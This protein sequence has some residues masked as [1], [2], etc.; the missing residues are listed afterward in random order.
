[1]GPQG[2]G[3]RGRR[4]RKRGR[5]VPEGR[6]GRARGCEKR[7]AAEKGT[8]PKQRQETPRQPPSSPPRQLPELPGGFA[9]CRPAALPI[10]RQSAPAAGSGPRHPGAFHCSKPPFLAAHDGNCPKIALEGKCPLPQAGCLLIGAA[11]VSARPPGT[12]W[13]C[14]PWPKAPKSPRTG[15]KRPHAPRHRAAK[16]RRAL[17]QALGVMPPHAP[18]A[19]RAGH[20]AWSHRGSAGAS[21]SSSSSSFS[22]HKSGRNRAPR[23]APAPA[24]PRR[25]PLH[26]AGPRWDVP[27]AAPTSPRGQHRGASVPTCAPAI[28]TPPPAPGWARP[29]SLSGGSAASPGSAGREKG[30]KRRK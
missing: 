5:A 25:A 14:W 20:G 3:H 27:G 13:H 21:S 12:M 11:T 28:A 30:E 15:C 19:P 16:P 17:T 29:G 26:P 1:M 2:W 7:K 10:P 8:F 18:R 4:I 9:R 23:P 24:P 22:G 6:R